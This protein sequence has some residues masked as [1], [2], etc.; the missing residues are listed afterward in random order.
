ME[1]ALTILTFTILA[2]ASV[3]FGLM[4]FLTGRTGDATV[5]AYT[6]VAIIM[7]LIVIAV[8]LTTKTWLVALIVVAWL[9]G[10]V[11]G[12]VVRERPRG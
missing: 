12:H 6:P 8:I 1:N 11:A 2:L 3:G 7:A 5:R 4:G 10:L 9:I